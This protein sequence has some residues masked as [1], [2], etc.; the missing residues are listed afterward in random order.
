M[1]KETCMT[2]LLQDLRY[3]LR[4]LRKSPGFV[5]SGVLA[6]A[7]GIGI[8]SMVFSVL[9]AVA[10]RP[11]PV[12]NAEEIVTIYQTFQGTAPRRV[13]GTRSL[14][15]L[16]EYEAYRDRNQT[17]AGIVAYTEE[18]LTLNRDEARRVVGQL[19]TC[20]Y[21]RV[22]TTTMAMG[23]GFLDE[24]CAS[25]GA[26]PVVVLSHHLWEQQ[27][28]SSPGILGQPIRLNGN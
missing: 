28:E 23:R 10:L 12:V 22:L 17:L 16:P 21:F 24:E 18:A 4:T 6:L 13:H 19:A 1:G 8:H 5:I 15:S 9:N 25:R 14:F 26:S 3:S 2:S 7:F 27:F 20:N 11:L